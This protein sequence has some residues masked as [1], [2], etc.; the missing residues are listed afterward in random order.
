MLSKLS[1][2]WNYKEK[3]SESTK[4]SGKG[5]NY[6]NKIRKI[7]VSLQCEYEYE[8]NIEDGHNEAEKKKIIDSY[9][10]HLKTKHCRNFNWHTKDS[11]CWL[12]WI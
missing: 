11:M 12:G 4:N 7:L 8:E 5:E 9:K 2:K 1:F 6:I 10:Q 3:F